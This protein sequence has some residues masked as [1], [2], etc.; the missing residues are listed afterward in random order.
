VKTIRP[1]SKI[2]D[3]VAANKGGIGQLSFA[4]GDTHP[5][6]A[7]VKKINIGGQEAS[8]NNS[9]YNITRPLYLITKGEATGASK[10]FIDWTISEDGQKIVKKYFVGR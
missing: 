6:A 1:D 2:I 8:V 10:T 9:N 4:L 5:K 7:M 3:S